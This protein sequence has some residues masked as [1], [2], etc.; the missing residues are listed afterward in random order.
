MIRVSYSLLGHCL[1]LVK[2]M[3]ATMAGFLALGLAGGITH[4]AGM[5][6][7]FVLAQIS[8]ERSNTATSTLQ[9]LAGP[10]LLPYHL[11]RGTTYIL[12]AVLLSGVLNLAFAFMP[13]RLFVVVPML[14]LAAVLFLVAAFPSMSVL[15][16]WAS[17]ISLP[18]PLKN[19]SQKISNRMQKE[20]FINRYM[21]GVLLGFMPCGLLLS[22]L[23]AACALATPLQS[24]LAM[25]AFTLGT[26]PSLFA[27]ALGGH[28]FKLLYPETFSRAR[29]VFLGFSALWLL[30][31]AGAS[32]F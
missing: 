6:G 26:M 13:V 14:M 24:G 18:V 4:C 23:M 1:D 9:K 16:P 11:G 29:Q 7:P 21:M 28:T 2:G 5:C 27:V 31:V 19:L 10:A 20:G 12:L 8:P 3:P 32:I 15:F 17:R 22:A 25:A 30:V